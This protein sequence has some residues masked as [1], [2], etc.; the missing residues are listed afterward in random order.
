ME[1]ASFLPTKIPPSR[2]SVA[3]TWV[4]HKLVSRSETVLLGLLLLIGLILSTRT[5]TFLTS[6]NML[7]I[8]YQSSWLAI[9]AI[10]VSM[11]I[12]IGGID[13]SVGALMALAGAVTALS[14]QAGLPIGLSIVL[15]LGSSAFFGMINGLL[16]G[17]IG[18]PPFIVTLGI[19][20]IARGLT[21]G[22][23]GGRPIRDLPEA[24]TRLGQGTLQ[25]GAFS[26][27]LPV[28][29]ML[30]VALLVAWLL[31]TT[32]LGRYIYALGRDEQA[33]LA[34]GLPTPQIKVL[35]YT[36]SGLL[37]GSGGIIL[38]ARLGVAA[39]TAAN[40]YELDI[41]AA[42]VIGG[43]SL[44]GGE[45]TVLGAILGAVLMQ[46]L[47]NGLVQLGTQAYWQ[48]GAIGIMTLIVLLLDYTRRRR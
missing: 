27:P 42:A 13:L 43:A 15:G 46:T 44:F 30:I 22:I 48:V 16:V 9:A 35:V 45:G 11:V 2:L 47:R 28:I 12:I 19:M 32:V 21:L 10:G 37:A 34:V 40:G 3:L 29:W 6:S 23:T 5:E 31:H 20:G 41:I 36:L 39:P 26:A 33:L 38:T 7:N 14:I 24:F 4:R 17:Q 8:A 18:L 1:K 25:F